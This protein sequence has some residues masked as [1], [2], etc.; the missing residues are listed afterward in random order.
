[1]ADNQDTTDGDG[2]V[3]PLKWLIPAAKAATE[4]FASQKTATKLE[5]EAL[6]EV[7]PVDELQHLTVDFQLA[8]IPG[9]RKD[10]RLEGNLEARV[11]QTCSVTLE[12]MSTSI[13]EPFSARMTWKLPDAKLASSE[14]AE[15]SILD[16]EDVELIED[17]HVPLG[18][19]VYETL[20][21]AIDPF[22]RKTQESGTWASG[23]GM[24]G[25]KDS[26]F[27][28]LGALK[29]APSNDN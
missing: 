21:A 29:K 4:G 25:A 20:T 9:S 16:I 19:I 12:P 10:L 27:A 3:A 14:D 6:A 1:M 17:E 23:W 22:P 18:R 13:N 2:P 8:P 26:P 5:C 28:S 24:D 15:L 7:L 11:D